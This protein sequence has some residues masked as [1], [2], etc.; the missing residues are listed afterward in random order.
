MQVLFFLLLGCGDEETPC[1]SLPPTVFRMDAV[2]NP[3]D[4]FTGVCRQP[5]PHPLVGIQCCKSVGA[6]HVGWERDGTEWAPLCALGSA[7]ERGAMAE[8][9]ERLKQMREDR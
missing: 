4:G 9:E 1:A 3:W 7:C 2:P 6:R 8:K 5:E